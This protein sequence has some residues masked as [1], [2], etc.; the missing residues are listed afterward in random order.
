[1]KG[2]ALLKLNRSDEAIRA[3]DKAIEIDP[4]NSLAWY[5]GACYFSLTNNKEQAIFNL[6]KAIKLNPVYTEKA[7]KDD[8]FKGLWNDE[9]FKQLTKQN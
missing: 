4:Q 2:Q 3:L 5:N 8:D 9:Q 6:K 1:M 7:L